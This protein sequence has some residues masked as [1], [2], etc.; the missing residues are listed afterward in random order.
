M[1]QSLSERILEKMPSF[2]KGQKRIATYILEHYKEAAFMTA[3]KLG[4]TVDV[5]ESTVVRFAAELDF[6][7]YP[8]LQHALQEM[9]R[10]R[11]TSLQRIEVARSRMADTE[12]LDH[13]L[14][15]DMQNI[16]HTLDEL[17]RE[18][19][20]NAVD[21]LVGARRVYVFGAGSCRA[22]ANFSA[23]YLKLLLPDVQLV[24]TNSNMEI[25]ED[26]LS[27]GP[28]DALLI[29]S[30][31][32]YSSKAVNTVDFAHKRGAKI[33]ALTDSRLSP[34]APY[35]SH[36]LLAHSDMATLVDSLV[37]PLSVLNSLI[38]AVSLRRM[39]QNREALTELE[40]LWAEYG[41]YQPFTSEVEPIAE[42]PQA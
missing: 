27:M 32:R 29:L 17:P 41:V 23:H 38:V 28:E 13:V 42:E 22:L 30:F 9:V 7:G 21:A 35:A 4:A 31:P 15:C 1:Q 14:S 34:I 6:A 19:F 24:Y 11:L 5:S 26:M 18:T 10:S 37:A 8:E 3:C 12:V 36:L 25:L 16:R 2:S 33:I 20:Y 40:Q 39:E